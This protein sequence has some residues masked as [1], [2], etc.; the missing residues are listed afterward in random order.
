MAKWFWGLKTPWK[1]PKSTQCGY[2][3]SCFSGRGLEPFSLVFV[4]LFWGLPISPSRHLPGL[5]H[6][7]RLVRWIA[8]TGTGAAEAFAQH[9][10]HHK[11]LEIRTD[12]RFPPADGLEVVQG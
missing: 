11:G 12:L 9:R 6:L 8:T 7:S 4:D 2:P 5:E 3:V 10:K 1:W